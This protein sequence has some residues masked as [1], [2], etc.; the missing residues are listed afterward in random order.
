M[1]LVLVGEIG[2]ANLFSV[3]VINAVDVVG[4]YSKAVKM[5]GFDRTSVIFD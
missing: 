1:V 4:G 5:L 2:E 3:F